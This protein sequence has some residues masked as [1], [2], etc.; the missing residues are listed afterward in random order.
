M[1]AINPTL[2]YTI[3]KTSLNRA[4]STEFFARKYLKNFKLFRQQKTCRYIDKPGRLDLGKSAAVPKS[5]LFVNQTVT[6]GPDNGLGT[7]VHL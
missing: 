2:D 4:E 6:Y 7:V 5:A 1:V 3:L